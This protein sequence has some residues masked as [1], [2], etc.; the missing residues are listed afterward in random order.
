MLDILFSLA[1]I[2]FAII[3]AVVVLIVALFL[4]MVV[5]KAIFA[6]LDFLFYY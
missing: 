3:G 1:A 6:F 2:P 5:V 4:G